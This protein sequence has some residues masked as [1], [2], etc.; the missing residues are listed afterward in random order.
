MIDNEA[1]VSIG[2][3]VAFA[4]VPSLVDDPWLTTFSFALPS[5]DFALFEDVADAV[6]SL[7]L[8]IS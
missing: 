7:T 6:E 1:D 5:D 8:A 4:C 2:T 3:V